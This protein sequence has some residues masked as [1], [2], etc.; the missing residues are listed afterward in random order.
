M[1]YLQ[2]TNSVFVTKYNADQNKHLVLL[3][4]S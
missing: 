4:N 1:Q 2:F 3:A